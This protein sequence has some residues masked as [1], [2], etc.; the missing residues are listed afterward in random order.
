M[1]MRHAATTL[2]VAA[3]LAAS[4]LAQAAKGSKSKE[5]PKAQA[6]AAASQAPAAK[7]LPPLKA[8]EM[9]VSTK[10][11]NH[12]V[13]PAPV[14]K[15]ITP[16][17]ADV[18]DAPT[19]MAGNK[20]V[21]LAFAPRDA[22]SPSV[23]VIFEL[24]NEAVI[25]QVVVP[26]EVEGAFKKYDAGEIRVSALAGTA[27]PKREFANGEVP[28]QADIE[29]LKA[30]MQGQQPPGFDRLPLS[31][32]VEFDKFVA[33]PLWALSDGSKKVSAFSL[34]ARPGQ[35]AVVEPS[36]FYRPNVTHIQIEG[37]IVDDQNSPTLFAVEELN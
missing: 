9:Y 8:G 7:T 22:K 24:E 28:Y 26:A 6:A 13:F 34:V 4:P 30:L 11:L 29:L 23:R 25:T 16:R 12:F 37:G 33:V 31:A 14:V 19:Y 21:L 18:V 1:N 2:I 20:Q 17:A 35:R 27:A 15:V 3:A 32:P 36:Q 5:K 10:D